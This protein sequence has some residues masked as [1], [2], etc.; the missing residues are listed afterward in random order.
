MTGSR[1]P[2]RSSTDFAPRTAR[3]SAAAT[4]RSDN[5]IWAVHSPWRDIISTDWH[6]P[7]LVLVSFVGFLGILR[8]VLARRPGRPSSAKLLWV[9]GV[10]VVGGMLFARMGALGGLPVWIYYG[11][12]A[13]LTWAL[14]PLV[15]RMSGGEIVRYL[16]M[17]L[18]IAP[19]IHVVF[20][21]FFGWTEY[22]P[23]IAVPSIADLLG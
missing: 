12:P 15:F 20:A 10:V 8:V 21:F 19:L 16:P 3:R 14:P 13:A 22:M 6:L 18:L 9:A 1:T 4:P 5:I 17:A 7:V 11:L 2:G 23:F